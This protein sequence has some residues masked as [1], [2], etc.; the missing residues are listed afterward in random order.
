VDIPNEAKR[1]RAVLSKQGEPD[2]HFELRRIGALDFSIFENGKNAGVFWQTLSKPEPGSQDT[3]LK[4][5]EAFEDCV[6][7]RYPGYT[8]K[9][10]EYALE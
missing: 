6:A 2:I 1:V 8:A 7:K 4:T 5:S 10:V 9:Q 3:I